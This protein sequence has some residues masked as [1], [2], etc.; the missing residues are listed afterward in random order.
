MCN[1]NNKI[2]KTCS[3]CSGT[4][5][6]IINAMETINCSKCGGTGKL[7]LLPFAIIYK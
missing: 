5:K 1:I 7:E 3:S 2:I 6:I 4:G